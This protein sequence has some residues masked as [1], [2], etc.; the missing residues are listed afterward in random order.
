MGV[1]LFV[2]V[3]VLRCNILA[4]PERD[5]VGHFRL[6]GKILW[7]I[8]RGVPEIGVSCHFISFPLNAHVS[9]VSQGVWLCILFVAGICGRSELICDEANS[10]CRTR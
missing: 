2:P 4:G 3:Y 7:N 1:H 8:C 5:S 9:F 10:S 6:P